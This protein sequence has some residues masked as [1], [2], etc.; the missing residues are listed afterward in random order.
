MFSNMFS[1]KTRSHYYFGQLV[2]DMGYWCGEFYLSGCSEES[3]EV[4][5]EEEMI[6]SERLIEVI[7]NL[8]NCLMLLNNAQMEISKYVK[9]N[10]G[11]FFNLKENFDLTHL[12]LETIAVEVNSSIL[13][14]GLIPEGSNEMEVQ[15]ETSCNNG[16]LSVLSIGD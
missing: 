11:L 2:L 15:I 12:S 16:K 6:E 14:W 1:K 10:S 8:E 5:I 9:N 13:L 3:I 4:F 7:K